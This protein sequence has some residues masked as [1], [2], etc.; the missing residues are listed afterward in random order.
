MRTVVISACGYMRNRPREIMWRYK[1]TLRRRSALPNSKFVA[2]Q[3]V[4]NFPV[5][6]FVTEAVPGVMHLAP[7]C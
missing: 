4:S 2:F 6:A 5:S 1:P 3:P 7:A